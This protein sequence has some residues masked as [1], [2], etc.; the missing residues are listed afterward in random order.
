MLENFELTMSGTLEQRCISCVAESKEIRE[1]T[2]EPI[3]ECKDEMNHTIEL[4]RPWS[5]SIWTSSRAE[6]SSSIARKGLPKMRQE[7]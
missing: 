5:P 2:L 3:E 4:W 1:E 7:H 6:F